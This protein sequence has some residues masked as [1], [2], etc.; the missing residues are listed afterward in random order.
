MTLI[1][2]GSID[3]KT[4]LLRKSI[5]MCSLSISVIYY[6]ITKELALSILIPLTIFSVVLDLSRYFSPK[7]AKVFYSLFGFMLREHEKLESKKNLNGATYVLL[8]ATF[9][10]AVFPKVFVIPAIAVLIV[11][12]VA[13]ALI[14][15]KFGVHKFLS[16]SLEGTL[17]FFFTGS[18]VILFTPKISGSAEEYLIGFIAVAV[19]AIA[20]NISH[21]WADDNLSI[22]VS[23]CLTMSLLYAILLP[24]L[25]LILPNVPI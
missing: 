3:Y 4:E 11:G 9:V 5:H 21:G 20:E 22:P 24:D 19:G 16:K 18:I 10:V 23:V 12:D 15:R 6:F 1:D 2:Q 13:A 17:A 8:A 25:N 14:G 7:I